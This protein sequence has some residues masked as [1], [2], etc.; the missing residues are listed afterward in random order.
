MQRTV[1]VGEQLIAHNWHQY[2]PDLAR[3]LNNLSQAQS[4]CDDPA[5][6]ILSSRRSA[7]IRAEFARENPDEFAYPL[8]LTLSNLVAF[9]YSQKNVAGAQAATEQLIAVYD[10]LSARDPASYRAQLAQCYHNI[11]YLCDDTGNK[12]EGI[13]YTLEGLKIREELLESD[14][15]SHA[16]ALAWSHNNAGN[17]Y[18]DLGDLAHAQP[19]L[20]RAYALRL[21]WVERAPGRQL[22]ELTKSANMMARLCQKKKDPEAEAIWLERVV[23]HSQCADLPPGERGMDSHNLAEALGRLGRTSEAAAAAS[24]AAKDFRQEF[25]SNSPDTDRSKWV[26]AGC[27]LTSALA[28]QGD[29]NGDREALAQAIELS[30]QV[31]APLDPE[32]PGL[33]FVWGALMNNL[34]HAQY[35]RGEL[36][37]QIDG[38]RQGIETLKASAEHHIKHDCKAA[39]EETSHLILRAQEA[40]AKLEGSNISVVEPDCKSGT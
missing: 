23:R 30:Q 24:S 39:A 25:A 12:T 9:E 35:R 36:L 19:H 2:A 28:L 4:S 1:E 14:F 21:Q 33:R 22:A 29:W 34:G 6:A 37:G 10:D 3:Y 17:M 40:V 16:L 20:E 11:G 15:D 26:N 5:G 27:N 7:Q 13:R 31:L 8:S 32:E 38:V 18:N